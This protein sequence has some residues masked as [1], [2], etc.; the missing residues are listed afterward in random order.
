MV[1]KVTSTTLELEGYGYAIINTPLTTETSLKVTKRWDCP[2][3]DVALYEKEQVTIRLL[4]NGVDTGRTETVSLKNNWTAVFSGLPY[5]DEE[6]NPIVYTVVETWQTDDWVPSY[7]P[8][9]STGGTIPTY[10]TV[11]T[12]SYRWTGSFELPTTGGSGYL[13]YILGGLLVL[14]PLVYGLRLRRRYR[15]GARE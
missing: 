9:S 5:V 3:E 7:G 4:A 1:K 12:N 11:V 14:A 2:A 15:K 6:E 10:E 13:I 8:V